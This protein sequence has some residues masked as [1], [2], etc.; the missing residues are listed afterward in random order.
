MKSIKTYFIPVVLCLMMISCNNTE[1]NKEPLPFSVANN[2][3]KEELMEWNKKVFELNNDIIKKTIERRNWNM[4]VSEVG[5]YS[6]I[7]S[8][9]DGEQ[10]S[11]GKVAEFAYKIYLLK[12]DMLLYSSDE[13][14]NR[15]MYIDRNQEETGLNEGLKM[16]KVGEKARFI[17]PHHL[18]FGVTGDGYKIPGYAILVYEVELISLTKPEK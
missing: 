16:M 14:G 12:E 10:A 15:L 6:Q 11:G 4:Q 5:L 7:L 1:T 13:S 2:V 17:I 9:T 18:A 3:H 8:K